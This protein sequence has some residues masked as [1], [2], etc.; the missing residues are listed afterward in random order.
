[1]DEEIIYLK[2][3]ARILTLMKMGVKRVLLCLLT[4]FR[5]FE[6]IGISP[7]PIGPVI[8][9]SF[10][11]LLHVLVRP[12]VYSKLSILQLEGNFSTTP[13][14]EEIQGVFLVKMVNKSI[15]LSELIK[16]HSYVNTYTPPLSAYSL[17]QVLSFMLLWALTYV[18]SLILVKLFG[19]YSS[20]LAVASMYV[21]MIKVVEEALKLASTS[22][23]FSKV[24]NIVIALPKGVKGV[25][26]DI[27]VKYA[28]SKAM[29]IRDPVTAQCI[30]AVG[31]FLI[32]WNIVVLT[33]MFNSS[34]K[35]GLKYSI[36][37]AIICYLL[38]LLLHAPIMG[39]IMQS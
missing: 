5:V 39:L 22:F 17:Y 30:S 32:L 27:I 16:S 19:G 20:S 12:V 9:L 25:E 1:M 33:A 3:S 14:V 4:P 15:E 29:E 8:V 36:I 11:V 21:Q 37:S 6:E 31:L 24:G 2:T 28:L 34:A 23:L 10:V 18:L 13:S 38:S 7:D 26:M 35:V